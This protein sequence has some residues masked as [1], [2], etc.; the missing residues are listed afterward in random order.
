MQNMAH[1]LA[2]WCMF[3]IITVASIGPTILLISPPAEVVC[4]QEKRLTNENYKPRTILRPVCEV[5]GWTH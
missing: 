2:G 3:A 5:M 4:W 1:W